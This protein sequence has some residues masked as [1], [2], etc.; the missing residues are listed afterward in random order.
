MPQ[1]DLNKLL[2]KLGEEMLDSKIQRMKNLL[3]IALPDEALYR[4]IMLSLGY[5]KN[6]VQFLE[7][8]I[9]LPYKEI[10]KLKNQPLIEKAL[11]YRAGF[12]QGAIHELPLPKDFDTSLRLEKSYWVFK[13]TR[14]AN[15]PDKRIKAVSHLLAET[16]EK[17]IYN[18][19]KNR[20]E[21][22]YV[23]VIDKT[24]AKKAVEKIMS[25]KG[26]GISRK[27]EMFFNIILP[28]F[29]ADDTFKNYSSFLLQIFEAHPP[30]DENSKIRKFYKLVSSNISSEKIQI[31][32]VKEYFGAMKYVE[33]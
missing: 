33:R 17:G 24:Y 3:K 1:T 26:V 13:G 32:N 19:F 10:Q 6:K 2:N 21:K 18:Y 16:T 12:I 14:P 28:F 9:L 29:L 4:E 8:A 27:R 5:P 7:L 11:L 22:N 31:S 15:F 20:I 25:F 30:L 23:D